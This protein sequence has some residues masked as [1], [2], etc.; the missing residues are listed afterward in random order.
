MPQECRPGRL[1]DAQDIASY[2]Y[3]LTTHRCQE[4]DAGAALIQIFARF[5][6]DASQ[7]LA[8]ITRT[9]PADRETA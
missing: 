2:G 6:A 9:N 5:F 4:A 1:V 8:F 7:R 3:D